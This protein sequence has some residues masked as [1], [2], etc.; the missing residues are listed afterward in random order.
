MTQLTC[1]TSRRDDNCHRGP[2]R[3]TNPRCRCPRQFQHGLGLREPGHLFVTNV[4]MIAANGCLQSHPNTGCKSPESWTC[5][6]QSLYPAHAKRRRKNR[7]RPGLTE[8]QW[9]SVSRHRPLAACRA[10]A[11]QD[12]RLAV[13]SAVEKNRHPAWREPS[14]WRGRSE[15][16]PV[17]AAAGRLAGTRPG[18]VAGTA[19]IG[20]VE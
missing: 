7:Y 3:L 1:K 16:R 4:H 2:R 5:D 15:P 17:P 6:E 8:L 14:A 12:C 20:P 11:N 19:R 10:W 18:D 9:K 13:S